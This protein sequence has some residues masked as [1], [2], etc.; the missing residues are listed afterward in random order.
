[1]PLGELFD[2]YRGFLVNDSLL[3]EVTCNVE[4]KD[5]AEHLRVSIYPHVLLG[6]F[7]L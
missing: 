2:Y 7:N 3:V 5:P 4:E 1:M 6:Q